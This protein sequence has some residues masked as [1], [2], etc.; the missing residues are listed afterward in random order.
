MTDRQRIGKR[1]VDTV[2]P[3]ETKWDFEVKGFGVRRQ[4]DV[5]SFVLKTSRQVVQPAALAD[6][7]QAR[8]ALDGRDGE[9]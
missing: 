3:G 7:R 5:I 4:K 1:M 9:G 2:K 6:N 8:L